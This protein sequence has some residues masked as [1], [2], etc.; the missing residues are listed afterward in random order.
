MEVRNLG[1]LLLARGLSDNELQDIRELE[2]EC[3][4]YE[5]LNMKLNWDMLVKR[6]NDENNDF[7][8]YVDNKSAK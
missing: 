5:R 6:S 1:N 4:S 3:C 2:M 7:L 8:Y